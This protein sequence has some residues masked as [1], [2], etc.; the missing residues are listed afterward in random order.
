MY[1]RPPSRMLIAAAGTRDP[2]HAVELPAELD[3][4]LLRRLSR[5]HSA[6]I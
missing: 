4:D 2:A 3:D 5:R 6:P 1:T